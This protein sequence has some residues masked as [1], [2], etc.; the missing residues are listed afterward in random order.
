MIE[1]IREVVSTLVRQPRQR[2]VGR[3]RE[4]LLDRFLIHGPLIVALVFLVLPIFIA[5]VASVED[6]AIMTS[7]GDLLPGR[8][9]SR[10]YY[11]AVV[12]FGFR[13]FLLNSLLMS[14]VI[15]V[16]QIV[17]A[18]FAALAIVYYRLPYKDVIFLFILSTLLL[19]VPVRFVPLYDLIVQLGWRNTM[20]AVTIPYLGSAVAV[21]L[22]RQR[23]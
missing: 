6:S 10:N 11:T 7:I 20:Y 1:A 19:P 5:A 15:V 23:T 8:Y 17:L 18:L 4:G 13:W 21:F 12:Q 9:A 3:R 22:L 2:V 14:A 16:G